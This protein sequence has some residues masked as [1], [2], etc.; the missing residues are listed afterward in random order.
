MT[1]CDFDDED[2]K[3]IVAFSFFSLLDYL[4]GERQL[5]YHKDTQAV[6]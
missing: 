1:G 6:L 2:V 3:D 5:P 4:P